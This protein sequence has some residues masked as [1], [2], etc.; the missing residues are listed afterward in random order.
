MGPAPVAQAGPGGVPVEDKLDQIRA[1]TDKLLFD[2]AMKLVEQFEKE[3]TDREYRA[4]LL[5]ARAYIEMRGQHFDK[6]TEH[7]EAAQAEL[8]ELGVRGLPQAQALS[9][10]GA[11]HMARWEVPECISTWSRARELVTGDSQRDRRFRGR[12]AY[13]LAGCHAMRGEFQ[14]AH[15]V[16]HAALVDERAAGAP[17][18]PDL[19]VTQ[20]QLG[21][22]SMRLERF[23]ES[24]QEQL[25][26]LKRC[27]GVAQVELVVATIKTSLAETYSFA[28]QTEQALRVVRQLRVELESLPE[29]HDERLAAVAIESAALRRAGRSAEALEVL[30]AALAGLR[31]HYGPANRDMARLCYERARL[32]VDLNRKTEAK[33]LIEEC[34]TE[35]RSLPDGPNEALIRV[36]DEQADRLGAHQP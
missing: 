14:R 30:E 15:E 28:G 31:A 19:A 32:L 4:R 13:N 29:A 36:L 9:V 23:D 35:A 17:P 1:L 6:A 24:I 26:A 34:F 12:M 5:I 20:S 11:I 2:E 27:E 3:S 7:V 22:F 33:P 18:C 16:G 25:D 10:V 21:Y 8:R